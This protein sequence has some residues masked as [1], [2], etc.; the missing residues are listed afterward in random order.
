LPESAG[1]GS[2]PYWLALGP[3][4]DLRRSPFRPFTPQE[5]SSLESN[6]C[7]TRSISA[8][9]SIEERKHWDEARSKPK[10]DFTIYQPVPV[11]ERIR[12]LPHELDYRKCGLKSPI[13][14][15]TVGRPTLDR[16]NS[17]ALFALKSTLCA[18]GMKYM[19][20]LKQVR[21]TC[22][23]TVS[24]VFDAQTSTYRKNI[25]CR[26]TL[27]TLSMDVAKEWIIY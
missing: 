11:S 19:R 4:F 12:K 16:I 21:V 9:Q 25:V 20:E 2:I 13:G 22:W 6:T 27:S 18:T 5:Y 17:V 15:M 14:S 23:L 3:D 8:V 10:Q 26:A 7:L 1:Q 24:E